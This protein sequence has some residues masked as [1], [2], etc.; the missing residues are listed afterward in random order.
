MSSKLKKVFKKIT[1]AN[2]NKIAEKMLLAVAIVFV[3]EMI[4]PQHLVTAHNINEAKHK[5]TTL[6]EAGDVEAWETHYVIATA[7]SSTV[8]QCDSTPFITA[9]NTRVRDGIIA[10]NFLP[11]GTR[12]RIPE[13]YGDKE[14]VVT[15]RMNKKYEYRI[16]V[17]METRQ[18][19]IDFG[20]Q[21]V[22]LEVYGNSYY[23]R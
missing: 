2:H 9:N 11:F 17:W 16:D 23:R 13:I 3:L 10:A 8:D 1:Q 19:A 15:D 6:P 12:V 5:Q 20:A 14:F 21:Y 18:E 4:F 22:K 7:Y